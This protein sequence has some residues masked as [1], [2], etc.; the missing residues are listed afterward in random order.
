VNDIP[1]GNVTKYPATRAIKMKKYEVGWIFSFPK[2]RDTPM[3][4]IGWSFCMRI[5]TE[6]AINPT[7]ASAFVKNSVPTTHE[8]I[9]TEK[10]AYISFFVKL[11]LRNWLKAK[12]AMRKNPST[13]S[14][15]IRVGA[16]SP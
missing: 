15:K 3:A 5:A 2:I 13:C 9:D 10:S 7:S 4:N 8:R 12:K 1:P 11:A 6:N 16:G 14:K